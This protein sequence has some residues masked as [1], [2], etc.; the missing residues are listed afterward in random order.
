MHGV[1]LYVVK[2]VWFS[3]KDFANIFLWVPKS[4]YSLK[5]LVAC[6]LHLR[7]SGI[8]LLSI[9]SGWLG[10]RLVKY[11]RVWFGIGREFPFK[12][13]RTKVDGALL[14]LMPICSHKRGPNF[15]QYTQQYLSHKIS[16]SWTLKSVPLCWPFLAISHH[17]RRLV[18]PMS[19]R[20]LMR[21]IKKQ[22]ERWHQAT[23][24]L[25]HPKSRYVWRVFF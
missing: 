14:G 10:F 16:Q 2:F 7:I 23:N 5:G 12:S 11:H 6:I 13:I 3:L 20:S 15:F 25:Q 18:N 1:W 22:N 8:L 17:S 19:K 4:V 24:I 21:G 9:L